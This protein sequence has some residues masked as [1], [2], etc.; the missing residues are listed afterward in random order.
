MRD[1]ADGASLDE[2]PEDLALARGEQVEAPA[3]V[4]VLAAVAW[5]PVVGYLEATLLPA[6]AARLRGRADE[7]YAGLRSLA[8]D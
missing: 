1:L 2:C 7:R 6:L 4:V 5:I 3:Q 8:K